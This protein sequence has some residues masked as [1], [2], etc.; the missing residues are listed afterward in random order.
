M[1]TARTIAI[2][3]VA[4]A[5]LLTG[6]APG[7]LVPHGPT[8]PASSIS[9]RQQWKADGTISDAARAIDGSM[10]TAAR[11]REGLAG[12]SITLD[13]GKACLFNLIRVDHGPYPDGYAETI[14]VYVSLDGQSFEPVH[15]GPGTRGSTYAN[16]M[17][18]V[19]ARYVRVENVSAGPRGWAVAEIVIR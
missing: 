18:P 19:L 14:A 6:C 1:N 15:R 7:G 5:V 11:G 8:D 17:T 2:V 9:P 16:L 13:L 3:A 10:E 4:G 12:Q